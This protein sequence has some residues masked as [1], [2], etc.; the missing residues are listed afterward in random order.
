MAIFFPSSL[1]VYHSEG[2]LYLI[3]GLFAV[4]NL[5]LFILTETKLPGSL[6]LKYASFAA[7]HINLLI[8]SNSL[9]YKQYGPWM[10]IVCVAAIATLFYFFSQVR[11]NKVMLTL[12]ALAASA[13]AVFKFIEL[14]SK[15]ASTSFFVFGLLFVALLLTGNVLF[16]RYLNRLGQSAQDKEKPADESEGDEQKSAILAKSYLRS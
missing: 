13:Y 5:V 1:Q 2:E 11:L 14:L 6:S 4:I 8:L 7:F 15:H 12:N 16:F 9:I 3:G 10:N